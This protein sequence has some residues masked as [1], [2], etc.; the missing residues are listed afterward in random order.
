MLLTFSLVGCDGNAPSD[1]PPSEQKQPG[2]ANSPAETPNYVGGA[3][4]V[5]CHQKQYDQWVG[6]HHDRAMQLATA[7]SVL[8]NFENGTFEYYG[9]HSTFSKNHDKFY[10]RTD[11][12]NG[13]LADFEITHTFGVDP[14]QQ[15]LITFPDGRLQALGIAWDTRSKE[16]GGQRWFHL[17]PNEPIT[18]SDSL[19]WTR[20]NQTWNYMCADCHSTNVHKNY[21]LEE[22]RYKTTWSDI[23]VGCEACHGPRSTHVSWAKSSQ[24]GADRSDSYHPPKGTSAL[25][26]ATE[27]INTCAKCHA[28]RS[29]LAEGYIPGQSFLNHYMPAL[30]DTDLYYPDGQVRDEVY[31]Y[32]SFLQSK[33][34][35]GGVRCTDCHDPHTNHLRKSL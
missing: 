32:G 17:Y 1:S 8:G 18:H 24:L 12:P 21:N 28:R 7:D 9:I 16:D 22:D 25:A 14:L 23:N 5:Q 31:V 10:V 27:E 26:T 30:L 13:K 11:G 4:C 33:M 15:Y 2:S 29:I 34:Y 6:S 3:V 20:N 19:H 35:Q